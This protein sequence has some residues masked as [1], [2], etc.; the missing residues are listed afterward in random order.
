M[1][2][3]IKEKEDLTQEKRESKKVLTQELSKLQRTGQKMNL[4][5]PMKTT[6]SYDKR[7]LIK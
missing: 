5:N 3:D 4:P 1:Q 6:L 7:L 2:Q